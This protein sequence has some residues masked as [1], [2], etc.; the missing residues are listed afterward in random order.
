MMLHGGIKRTHN[1]VKQQHLTAQSILC[2]PVPCRGNGGLIWQDIIHGRANDQLAE[3]S[4][5]CSA[6][7]NNCAMAACN[8]CNL[9]L[10]SHI[11]GLCS[12]G[13]PVLLLRVLELLLW[14]PC[15]DSEFWSYCFGSPVLILRVLELQLWESCADT[16]GSSATAFGALCWYWGFWSYSFGSPVLIFRALELQL[17]EPGVDIESSGAA[18]E[19]SG[20][21]TESSGASAESSGAATEALGLQLKALELQLRLWSSTECSVSAHEALELKL[22]LQSCNWKHL[23]YNWKL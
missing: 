11:W 4:R 10:I 3:V 9:E 17:G 21:A 2:L 20:T 6:R 15:A 8:S 12:F 19:S 7:Q 5:L 23:S 16:E 1:K 14:E 22:K 18:T 13:S